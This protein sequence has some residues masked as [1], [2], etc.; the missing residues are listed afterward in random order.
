MSVKKL[1][2][3]NYIIVTPD[4]RKQTQLCHGNMLRPYAEKSSNLV[5]EPVNVNVVVSEP[6]ELGSELSS[7][8]LSPTNT[9]ILTNFN[10][11]RKL[12]FLLTRII[13]LILFLFVPSENGFAYELVC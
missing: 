11:L 10:V 4:R 3:P 12:D 6:K 13:A 2:D 5:E 9:K 1:H 8:H 7:S